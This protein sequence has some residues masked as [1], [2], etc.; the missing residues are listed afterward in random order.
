MANT[1]TNLHSISKLG[2]H[3]SD[4]WIRVMR[5]VISVTIALTVLTVLVLVFPGK[6]TTDNNNLDGQDRALSADSFLSGVKVSESAKQMV[7]I[8]G[9]ILRIENDTIIINS[10]SG[11][12]MTLYTSAE[13]QIVRKIVY[14]QDAPASEEIIPVSSLTAGD[15]VQI[16]AKNT[17]SQPYTGTAQ[18]IVL[19]Q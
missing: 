5:S 18:K 9:T 2:K 15:T 17:V 3:H 12:E 10:S 1:P 19:S 14:S 16:L 6:D 7:G 11:Q 4:P 13:T 8:S